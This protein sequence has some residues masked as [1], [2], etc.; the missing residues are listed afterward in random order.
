MYPAPG[1]AYRPPPRTAPPHPSPLT[2]PPP[3]PTPSTHSPGSHPPAS[4]YTA[5]R[6][7]S[8]HTSLPQPVNTQEG[9]DGI[10]DAPTRFPELETLSL[11][12]LRVLDEERAKFDD[13]VS[14]HAHQR[15]VDSVLSTVRAD[16]DA[17]EAEVSKRRP[18]ADDDERQRVQERVTQLQN[19]VDE[20]QRVKDEWLEANSG[21]RLIERLRTAVREGEAESDQL[22]RDM[23]SNSL[24]FDDFLK[25]YLDCRK[26]Y[27]QHALKLE[28]L[29]LESKR[30]ISFGD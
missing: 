28:Q 26:R 24:N 13:F 2:P 20:L 8:Q 9:L 18:V 12:D 11:T 22:E 27:H 16:V 15:R 21:E 10:P 1:G 14:R 25:L 3:P 23:L 29:K 7:Q 6:A 17:V 30:H 5:P 19:E 4:G